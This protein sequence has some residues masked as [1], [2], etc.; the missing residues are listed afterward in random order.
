MQKKEQRNEKQG[1]IKA[2]IEIL[3]NKFPGMDLEWIK[4]CNDS[5]ITK[6]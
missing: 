4:G 2:I 5:Q 1:R 3:L 6:I